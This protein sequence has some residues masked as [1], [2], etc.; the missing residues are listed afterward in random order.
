MQLSIWRHPQQRFLLRRGLC[1]SSTTLFQKC[2]QF[3]A[4]DDLVMHQLAALLRILYSPIL[5]HVAQQFASFDRRRAHWRN[6][7][8]K[9]LRRLA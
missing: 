8:I 3:R 6:H 1:R 2:A 5:T 9:V 4:D 7:D